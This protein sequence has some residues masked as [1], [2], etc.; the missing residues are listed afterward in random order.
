MVARKLTA[1]HH[2]AVVIPPTAIATAAND[3]PMI[4]PRFHCALDNPTAATRC[5][6]GTSRGSVFWK[7]GKPNAFTQPARKVSIAMPAG[8]A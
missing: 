3:G 2:K 6:R 4:L 5:S 1:L 8:V 7:D